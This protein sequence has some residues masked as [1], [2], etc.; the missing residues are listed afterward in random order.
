MEA[1]FILQNC[2]EA[3]KDEGALSVTMSQMEKIEMVDKARSVIV[4]CLEDKVLKKVMFLTL[5]V[6]SP[7]RA[8]IIWRDVKHSTSAW[9]GGEKNTHGQSEEAKVRI[10]V[11]NL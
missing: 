4:L 5:R 1:V 2:A 6:M 9:R 10:L 7:Y 3:L 11:I 8:V